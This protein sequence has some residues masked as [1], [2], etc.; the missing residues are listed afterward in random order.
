MSFPGIKLLYCTAG[1]A[2]IFVGLAVVC[3]ASGCWREVEYSAPE[4]TSHEEK[5]AQVTTDEGAG[6]AEP[7]PILADDSKAEDSKVAAGEFGDD[8]AEALSEKQ[9]AAQS[10]EPVTPI[11]D[12]TPA[13]TDVGERYA[14]KTPDVSPPTNS[15]EST[16]APSASDTVASLLDEPVDPNAPPDS[17]VNDSMLPEQREAIA[18]SSDAPIPNLND[19]DIQTPPAVENWNTRRAAWLLGSKLSLAALA[20]EHGAPADQVKKLFEQSTA[21]A[22][23]LNAP[24]RAL[25][26]RPATSAAP[27]ANYAALDYLFSEGQEI[28]SEL[29]KG[30]GADHAAL[31]EVAVK[32]NILLVIYKPASPTTEAIS[33]AI[34]RAAERAKLPSTL[35]QPLLDALAAKG[36]LV[37]LRKAVYA[38]H[39]ATDK[40]LDETVPR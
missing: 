19:D 35:W 27:R 23:K 1:R 2:C 12:S 14:S 7:P 40:Y 10:T 28:G 36:T 21:L 30:H 5:L 20:N 16:T 32:S 38:M 3:A 8:L 6:T 17:P 11:T 37:D 25:P 34:E 4:T 13:A 18:E 9:P 26:T 15:T 24:L 22:K 33:A 29:A 31:F 39:E